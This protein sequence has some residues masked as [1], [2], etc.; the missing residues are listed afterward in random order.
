MRVL[1]ST[2]IQGI[3]VHVDEY[4]P[5]TTGLQPVKQVSVLWVFVMKGGEIVMLQM[6]TVVR[7]IS[8]C[9]KIA[10]PAMPLKVFLETPVVPVTPVSG[11]VTILSAFDVMEMRA[12]KDSMPVVGVTI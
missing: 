3:V 4:A 1:I 11:C 8:R 12:T 5:Y 7:P 10:A 2:L 9:Q 6:K